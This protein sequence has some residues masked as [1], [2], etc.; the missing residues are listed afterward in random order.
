[1]ADVEQILRDAEKRA[2]LQFDRTPK[3]PVVAQPFP[4]FRE[5]NA[6]ANYTRAGAGRL[7]SRHRS[8]FRCGPSA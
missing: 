5:A 6:A 7:A 1:M 4:R 3:A 8:R 2:A